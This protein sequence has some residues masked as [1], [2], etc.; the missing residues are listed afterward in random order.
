LRRVKLLISYDG[1]E[2]TDG[3]CSPTCEYPGCA[4]DLIE[5]D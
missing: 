2:I 5:G 4:E 3:K 1:T